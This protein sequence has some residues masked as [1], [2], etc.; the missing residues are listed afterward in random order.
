M[1]SCAHCGVFP[2]TLVLGA[3][4]H[5]KNFTI[6]LALLL[7]SCATSPDR[8]ERIPSHDELVGT[9]DMGDGLGV[10]KTIELRATGAYEITY[11]GAV[12]RGGE[13]VTARGLWQSQG[14]Y[15]FF[16]NANGEYNAPGA[17]LTYAE[18][19]F[20]QEKPAFALAK[21]LKHGR[22]HEWWVFSRRND[23]A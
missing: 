3:M 6:A 19:F 4:K 22:V 2:L 21:D 11:C 5:I 14:K 1:L 8:V 13:S 23:G 18:I 15:L 12:H 20:Y 10:C 9:Y 16:Y 17:D 7:A